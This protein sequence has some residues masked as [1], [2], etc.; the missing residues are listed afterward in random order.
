MLPPLLAK[1]VLIA[2]LSWGLGHA[3]RCIPVIRH[4]INEGKTVIIAS[5]SDALALLRN[6]FPTVESVELPAYNI[7]YKH[8]NMFLAML[9]QLPHILKTIILE[10]F[11]LRKIVKQYGIEAIISDNR[12]G[13]FSFL[14]LFSTCKKNIF[15]THQINIRINTNDDIFNIFTFVEYL[16]GAAHRL[17][18]NTFFDTTWIPDFESEQASLAGRLSHGKLPKN[19]VFVGVLTR[20][21]LKNKRKSS[22]KNSE[23]TSLRK[24]ILVVLSGPEPQRTHFEQIILAQAA[25]LPQHDFTLIQGKPSEND[26]FASSNFDSFENI[27]TIPFLPAAALFTCFENADAIILRSGYSSLM[28]LTMIE[29]P[30]LLVPTPQQTE[31]EYLANR[32]KHKKNY[33]VQAQ[34]EID[35]GKWLF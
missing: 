33:T 35:L 14:K 11:A 20:F 24:Q 18:I 32:F 8:K 4:C 29:K 12:Y 6:E 30:V 15:I 21:T 34:G 19:S 31:Q 22:E 16:I 2:P 5:D 27:K 25:R 10:Y 9:V 13:C 3:T 28:D 7:E 17:Y 1:T 23:K 26:N